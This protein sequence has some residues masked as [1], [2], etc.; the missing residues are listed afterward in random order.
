MKFAVL[1]SAEAETDLDAI[2]SFVAIRDPV[3]A[4]K[5]EARVVTLIESLEKS[6]N[7][8][9]VVPE[10]ARSGVVTYRELISEPWRVM[11][12]IEARNV[13]VV[14]VVDGRRNIDELLSERTRRS[15]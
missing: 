10:L 7:R 5:I 8:G 4:D 3:A 15:F 11:Y 9:R 12:R 6:P 1:I 2:V 14:A 13:R